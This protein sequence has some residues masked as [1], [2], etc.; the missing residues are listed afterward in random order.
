MRYIFNVLF[1]LQLHSVIFNL[2]FLFLFYFYVGVVEPT[3]FYFERNLYVDPLL[4]FRQHLLRLRE[5]LWL[6]LLVLGLK[7]KLEVDSN[8][9]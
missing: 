5:D 4:C 9:P 3:R 7:P 2:Y 1:Y 8:I 6:F